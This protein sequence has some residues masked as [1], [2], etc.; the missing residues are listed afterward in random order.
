MR[1]L[2]SS[3]YYTILKYTIL[4][5]AIPYF[6]KLHYTVLYCTTDTSSSCTIL[7]CTIPYFIRYN[8]TLYCTLLPTRLYILNNTV[9]HYPK[10]FF[11]TIQCYSKELIYRNGEPLRLDLL[12]CEKLDYSLHPTILR[13]IFFFYTSPCHTRLYLLE[14]SL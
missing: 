6:S 10:R 5:C 1:A 14:C 3:T 12:W 7:Y 11:T 2:L 8:V 9:L 4:Y 13:S